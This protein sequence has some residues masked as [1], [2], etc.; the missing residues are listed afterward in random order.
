[1]THLE[2]ARYLKSL[3][4]VHKEAEKSLRDAALAVHDSFDSSWARTNSTEALVNSAHEMLR[5]RYW[6]ARLE[7]KE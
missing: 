6:E 5:S 1:M 7:E 2:R 3:E 4:A